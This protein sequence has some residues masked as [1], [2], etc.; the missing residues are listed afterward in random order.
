MTYT[1]TYTAPSGRQTYTRPENLHG[2]L[3]RTYTGTY[4]AYTRP[5]LHARPPLYRGGRVFW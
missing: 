1:G 3:V 5:D 4:T 2:S